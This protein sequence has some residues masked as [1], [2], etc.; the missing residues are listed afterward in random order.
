MTGP[1]HGLRVFDLTRI[2]T[3]PT[4]AQPLGDL[5]GPAQACPPSPCAGPGAG[6][7]PSSKTLRRKSSH[8]ESGQASET[9]N[10]PPATTPAPETVKHSLCASARA[11]CKSASAARSK[12]GRGAVASVRAAASATGGGWPGARSRAGLRRCPG[13]SSCPRGAGG[14]PAG[15]PRSMAPAPGGPERLA[16]PAP[17]LAQRRLHHGDM[18]ALQAAQSYSWKPSTRSPQPQTRPGINARSI[19]SGSYDRSR[20][21]PNSGFFSTPI[22]PSL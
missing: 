8:S 4:C 20:Q 5:G 17:G 15:T 11:R 19:L 13:G 3:E 7:R 12:L 6:A 9:W 21:A 1:L 10:R 14:G 22:S 2:L 16:V 18:V